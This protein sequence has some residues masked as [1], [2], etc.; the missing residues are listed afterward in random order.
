[1]GEPVRIVD[2]ARDLIHL[3][4]LT[5]DEDI[6]IRFTGMRP[7]EKLFE[8]LTLDEEKADKTLHPKILVGHVPAHD[9]ESVMAKLTE[10]R[11]I[12]ERNEPTAAIRQKLAECVPE[13]RHERRPPET[14]EHLRLVRSTG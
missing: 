12:V 3:S 8:E 7:G 10:M 9:A 6:A 13:Y 2:L 11:A 1:M 4:G 14:G 5:P